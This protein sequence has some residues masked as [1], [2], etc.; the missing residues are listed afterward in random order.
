[1]RRFVRRIFFVRFFLVMLDLIQHPE[2]KPR[3]VM[4]DLDPASREKHNAS[5]LLDTGVK[6]QDKEVVLSSSLLAHVLSTE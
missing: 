3:T 6:H 4:L 1:M 5:L 2:K